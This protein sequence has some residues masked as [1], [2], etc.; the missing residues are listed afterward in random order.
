MEFLVE[1][2]G[3]SAVIRLGGELDILTAPA[4]ERA[5]ATAVSM[6]VRTVVLD[7]SGVL[8]IDS[9]GLGAVVA[10]HREAAARRVILRL[11]A[12]ATPGVA[13]VLHSTGLDDVLLFEPRSEA[14][15]AA[16]GL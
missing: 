6:P 3:S 10:A 9:S 14:S 11:S 4:V 7:I 13:R 12:P 8:F 1:R 2:T 16:G 15:E 5:M